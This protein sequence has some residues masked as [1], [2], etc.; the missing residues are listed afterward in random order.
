[1]EIDL[2]RL[3]LGE[4]QSIQSPVCDMMRQKQLNESQIPLKSGAGAEDLNQLL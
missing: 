2:W 4:L 3:W 1:M